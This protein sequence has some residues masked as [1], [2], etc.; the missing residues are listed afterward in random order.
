MSRQASLVHVRQSGIA[1]CLL[2]LNTYYKDFGYFFAGHRLFVGVWQQGN[3][4]GA[5]GQTGPSLAQYLKN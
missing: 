4:E 3:S 5:Q 1:C 2:V